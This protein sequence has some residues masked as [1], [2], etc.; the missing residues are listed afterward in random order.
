MRKAVNELNETIKTILSLRS[1]RNYSEKKISEENLNLI[2]RASVR[3]ANASGRQSYSII[4]VDDKHL[5]KKY[6]Y[7]ADKGLLYC[8]D[9]N[10]IIDAA[11]YLNHTYALN[12]LR[13]F[14]T[15]TTDTIL[16]AQTAT[17]AA[18]SLGIDSLF[19]NSVHRED[20]NLVYKDFNLPEKFCFP[21]IAL[22]L[23]YAAEE[24]KY[25]KGRLTNSGVI[26]Y[27]R[28][29]RLDD[30]ELNNLIQEYDDEHKRIGL[31]WESWQKMGFKHYLDWFYTR[32]SR[33]IPQ[34]KL[35]EFH[36]ILKKTGFIDA[37]WYNEQ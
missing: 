28:Y 15:G 13:F 18:K 37:R 31:T 22:C 4:V 32:W 9:F 21:L 30:Q 20:L 25:L 3:A 29:H 36:L 34:E 8:V 23:G 11:K 6:F 19:T 7:T 27:N 17:I 10:R 35:K 26:H 14:I 16:A 2:I 24:P 12:S 5:L 1:I 33:E